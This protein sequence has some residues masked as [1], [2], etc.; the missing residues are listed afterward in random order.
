MLTR[1]E[2]MSS[3]TLT[4]RTEDPDHTTLET[5]RSRGAVGDRLQRRDETVVEFLIS[6]CE[7]SAVGEPAVKCVCYQI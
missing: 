1:D 5:S 2:I 6:L 4:M 7:E 3:S